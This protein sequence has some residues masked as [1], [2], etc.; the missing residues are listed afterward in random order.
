MLELDSREGCQECTDEAIVDI[1]EKKMH[2]MYSSCDKI[3]PCSQAV[4]DKKT[5]RCPSCKSVLEE[6]KEGATT[7]LLVHAVTIFG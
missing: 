2:P 4:F 6:A 5:K 7:H 3:N 1:E